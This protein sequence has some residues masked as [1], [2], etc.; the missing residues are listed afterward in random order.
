MATYIILR[1]LII[2]MFVDS[3]EAERGLPNEIDYS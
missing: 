2:R 1:E 3:A